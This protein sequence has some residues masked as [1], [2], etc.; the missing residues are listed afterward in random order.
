M[1]D[2]VSREAVINL[3]KTNWADNDG[4]TA[5]QISI[6]DVRELPSVEP[7]RAKGHW[8]WRTSYGIDRC[9]CSK[10]GLGSWEM[11][12]NYCPYCGA[13]MREEDAE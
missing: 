7:E 1:I 6:D 2:C 10:C 5:M 11:E 13:D 9:K 12:F 3:M 8:K 4:D